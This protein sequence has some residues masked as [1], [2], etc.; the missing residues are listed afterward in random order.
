MNSRQKLWLSSFFCNFN[1]FIL[2]FD[3]QNV[4]VKP[5]WPNFSIFWTQKIKTQITK[6]FAKTFAY[7]K[8]EYQNKKFCDTSLLIY[9][10]RS[11]ITLHISIIIFIKANTTY[12]NEQN[13]PVFSRVFWNYFSGIPY[14]ENTPARS[15][16]CFWN[17]K[18]TMKWVSGHNTQSQKYRMPKYRIQ[19]NQCHYTQCDI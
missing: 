3:F 6:T 1:N 2:R 10:T 9:G 16:K 7:T 8:N 14:T 13:L 12:S 17:D 19:K 11:G 18:N 4:Y 15:Q 5:N